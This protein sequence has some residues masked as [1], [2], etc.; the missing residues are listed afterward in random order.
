MLLV[1]AASE[2]RRLRTL[3]NYHILDTGSEPAYDT[4][5][6]LAATLCAAPMAVVSL[7]DGTREWFKASI[8]LP[9]LVQLPRAAALGDRTARGADLYVAS[10]PSADARI[11]LGPL[12]TEH[13]VQFY[14]GVPL[15]APGGDRIGT[16]AVMDVE[17]RVLSDRQRQD[18]RRLGGLVMQELERRKRAL[19]R[20]DESDRRRIELLEARTS[21][22]ELVARLAREL[23][24][25]V[26]SIVG[27]ARLFEEDERFPVEA[28]ESMALVRASGQHLGAIADDVELM[29]QI[30]LRAADPEWRPVDLPALLD[31]AGIELER[32]AEVRVVADATLLDLVLRRLV[33]GARATG[34][35][36]LARIEQVPDGVAIV[37][38]GVGTGPVGY[39]PTAPIAVQLARRVAERHGGGVTVSTVGLLRITLA[40]DPEETPAARPVLVVDRAP[41]ELAERLGGLGFPVRTARTTDEVAALLDT[42]EVALVSLSRAPRGLGPVLGVAGGKVGLVALLGPHES[43]GEGWDVALRAPGLPPDLRAAIHT[44]A[45]KARLRYGL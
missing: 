11:A 38:S 26:T 28:R 36:V 24:G 41:E 31:A 33:A 42:V 40:T 43:A 17:P 39:V 34:A 23:R 29:S 3:W 18:L 20:A 15:T 37:L 27:F 19:I 22:A 2:E 10:D 6:E 5:A 21:Q 8:G 4:I 35:T 14:A 25:P 13:H 32:S 44:A 30:E 12:V 1:P 16:L 7:I 45:T 9:G